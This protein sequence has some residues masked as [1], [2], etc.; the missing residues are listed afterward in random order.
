YF[1]ITP[2]I[3]VCRRCGWSSVG[4]YWECPR[5]GYETDVW[6]RIVGYYRPVRS[7]N[8]GKRAEFKLRA[9]YRQAALSSG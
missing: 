1:S 9:T 3:S 5:C 4:T 2:T 7:W 6:S 8:V